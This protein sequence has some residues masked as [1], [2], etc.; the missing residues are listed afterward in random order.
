MLIEINRTG[1]SR[2]LLVRTEPS[3][4]LGWR[5]IQQSPDFWYLRLTAD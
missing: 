4:Q 5:E 1:N 3:A 2:L